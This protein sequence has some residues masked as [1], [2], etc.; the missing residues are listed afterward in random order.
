MA[1]L[2]SSVFVG[3]GRRASLR[4]YFTTAIAAPGVNGPLTIAVGWGSDIV[5]WPP[6]AATVG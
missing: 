2:S 1:D 4:G 3:C 6:I 5:M